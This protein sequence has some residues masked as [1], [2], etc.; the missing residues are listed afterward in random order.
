MPSIKVLYNQTLIDIAMEYYGDASYAMMLAVQLGRSITSDLV[1]GEI[2][3][4]PTI[5]ITTKEK[6]IA[7]VM[8]KKMHIPASNDAVVTQGQGGIGFMQIGNDFIVS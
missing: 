4:I 5:D 7:Y 3:V 1:A 2:L 8:Q 6:S